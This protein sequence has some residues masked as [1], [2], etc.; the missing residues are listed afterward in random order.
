M[1]IRKN[2]IGSQEV[3]QYTIGIGFR[4]FMQHRP[5]T[6]RQHYFLLHSNNTISVLGQR[7]LFDSQFL[8]VS[9]SRTPEAGLAIKPPP[10]VQVG[11]VGAEDRYTGTTTIS[12]TDVT[13]MVPVF[14]ILPAG[15]SRN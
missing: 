12:H 3:R 14:F 11:M 7:N 8:P 9:A 15:E 6:N 10:A 4:K 13:S 2:V 1:I 5:D